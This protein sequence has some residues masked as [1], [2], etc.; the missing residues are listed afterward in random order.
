MNTASTYSKENPQNLS[1][2]H[3][4]T[5][6]AAIVL[7]NG[8]FHS[9]EYPSY[10]DNGKEVPA[11]NIDFSELSELELEVFDYYF[12]NGVFTLEC[13]TLHGEFCKVK[14]TC[15]KPLFCWNEFT[16]DAWFQE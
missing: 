16:E 15:G 1:G 6:N 7:K 5:G 2:R 10:E 3:K 12:E 4:R 8:A 9:A 11:Q 13:I 14:L